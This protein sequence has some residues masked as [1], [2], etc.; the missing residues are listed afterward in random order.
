MQTRRSRSAS[1]SAHAGC[2]ALGFLLGLV[3]TP[4]VLTLLTYAPWPIEINVALTAL[5]GGGMWSRARLRPVGVGVV[6]ATL[7]YATFF[8]Y[9]FWTFYRK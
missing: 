7:A 5:V 2:E 1:N 9:L 6:V 3:A 4:V 8:G